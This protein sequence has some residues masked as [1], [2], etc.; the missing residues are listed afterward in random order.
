MQQFKAKK[1]KE[2][3]SSADYL[4]H[5][6]SLFEEVWE[7]VLGEFDFRNHFKELF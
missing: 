1:K 5:P 3:K 2:K 6:S 4:L 7:E